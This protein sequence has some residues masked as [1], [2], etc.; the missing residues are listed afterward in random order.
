MLST[1]F[2]ISKS[3]YGLKKN[4][5]TGHTFPFSQ[6]LAIIFILSLPYQNFAH[7]YACMSVYICN[8]TFLQGIVS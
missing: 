4:S 7:V 5:L 2:D 8:H 3:S 6:F 1:V